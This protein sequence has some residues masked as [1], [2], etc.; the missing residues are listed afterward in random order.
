[1]MS[2]FLPLCPDFAAVPILYVDDEEM[3]RK[4]FLR[5]V[6]RDFKVFVA[7]GADQAIEMLDD[8]SLGIG[9]LVTDY[10]MPERDGV[11]LL[12]Q[13]EQ[14]FSHIVRVL[15]T[16][17]ADREVLLDA[18]NS[19]E[20]FRILEKPLEM[21]EVTVTL[22]LAVE[23]A[24]ERNAR[25]QR[26]DAMDETL[27]FLAHELN[28]PLAAISHFSQGIQTRVNGR[29]DSLGK[30]SVEIAGAASRIDAGAKYCL[31]LL[32]SFVNSIRAASIDLHPP[33]QTAHRLALALLDTYPL[34]HAQRGAISL[35]VDEDFS[36][37][38]LPNCVMLVLSSILSNALRAVADHAEPEITISIQVRNHPQI[39]ISN[40]GPHIPQEILRKLTQVP[41]TSHAESGGSGWGLV[42]CKRIMESFG[43]SLQISSAPPSHTTMTLHFP[44]AAPRC[45]G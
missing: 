38:A 9:V 15:V 12:R 16:A 25:Q 6:G 7:S 26:L 41:F 44:S 42:F 5:A 32:A 17:Y 31:S 33:H 29:V 28:T 19:G 3:A 8:E 30:L 4:Y 23:L 45:P 2:D 37:A 22:K 24:R 14:E 11:S 21:P 18:V 1:M 43:G 35:D 13:V 39:R 34:T 36:I 10:R 40:N 20:V 27:G